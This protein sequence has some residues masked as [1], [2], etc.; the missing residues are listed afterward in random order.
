[1]AGGIEFFIIG[2]FL[3]AISLVTRYDYNKKVEETKSCPHELHDLTK[4][5]FFGFI[6]S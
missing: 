4:P 1:M 5:V 3:L 2:I 6:F